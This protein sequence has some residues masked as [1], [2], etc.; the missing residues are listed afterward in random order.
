MAESVKL[1]FAM[2]PPIPNSATANKV[3]KM[4]C[5]P[6]I[7]CLNSLSQ[8]HGIV[9][10]M[11][12]LLVSKHHLVLMMKRTSHG[13]AAGSELTFVL[14]ICLTNSYHRLFGLAMRQFPID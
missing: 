13:W 3:S 5:S 9:R 7:S 2:L 1:K 4:S 6:L 8:I 14:M 12:K 11:Q 10:P